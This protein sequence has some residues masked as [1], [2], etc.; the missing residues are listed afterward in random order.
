M[1]CPAD[2][3]HT[4]SWAPKHSGRHHSARR[5]GALFTFL[6]VT[7]TV[8]LLT[9]CGGGGSSGGSGR[10]AP[11]YTISGTVAGLDAGYVVLS[12]GLDQQQLVVNPNGSAY[13]ATFTFDTS[14]PAGA[15]YDI[16]I[17]ND[18]LG[19]FGLQCNVINGAGIMST[20]P[21]S[22]IKVIC[23]RTKSLH[24]LAGKLALSDAVDGTLA[25]ATFNWPNTVAVNAAGYTFIADQTVVR[26]IS[27]AGV[28]TTLAGSYLTTGTID[29]VGASASFSC[30]KDITTD[31]SGNVYVSE[32]TNVIRRITSA[33]VVTTLAGSADQPPGSADGNG[34][35]ARFHWPAGLA[36][37]G[38]GNILV[39][40][41]YNH[42]IRRVTP[43]GVV[44]T[45]AGSAGQP[46]SIDGTISVSRFNFPEGIAVDAAGNILVADSANCTIRIITLSGVVT[47]VA[48]IAG[49][50]GSADGT[51][52]AATF[53]FPT[54]IA[55][56][57]TGNILVADSGNNTIRH[58]AP[59]GIVTTLAGSA[60]QS[61]SVDGTGSAARFGYVE[62]LTVDSTGNILVVDLY[63]HMIRHITPSGIVTTFAGNNGQSK[64]IDGN[65]SAASFIS[66]QG[67]VMGAAGTMLV[68][69][70][71][72][73]TIRQVTPAGVVTTIAGSAGQSG[74]DDG[75]SSAARFNVPTGLAVDSIGNI[76]VADTFN[77]AIR[78]ITP[79]GLVTTMAGSAG[80]SGSTDGTGSDA[81]FNYPKGLAIDAA[82]NV[83]VAD[84]GNHTIRRI[85]PSGV[86]TTLAGSAGQAGSANG[87]GSTARFKGPTGLA[88]DA[89][90]NILVADTGN[91]RIRSITPSGVVVPWA[92]SGQ[93][94][95]TDGTGTTAEFN[96]PQWLTVD[97]GGNIL[98]A[99]HG[100]S[101]N[102]TIRRI[103]PSRVVTARV[104]TTIA[105]GRG[106]EPG[107]LAVDAAGNIL[108]ADPDG[109]IWRLVPSGVSTTLTLKTSL[110]A[111]ADGVGSAAYFSQ[112]RNLE[113]DA[114]GNVFVADKGNST[115]RR[116]AP[117]GT[118]STLA[119]SQGQNGSADGVGSAARF[120]APV[121]LALDASTGDL[122][123]ADQ[124]NHNIRRV[125]MAGVVTT[126][127]GQAGKPGSADG[128]GTAAQF[129]GP[130]GIDIDAQGHIWVADTWNNTVRKITPAGDVSTVAGTAGQWGTDDGI[131]VAARF[132]SPQGIVVDTQGNILVADT[133]NLTLRKIAADGTVTTIVGQAGVSGDLD[134]T[135]NAAQFIRPTFLGRD[136]VGHVYVVDG[137]MIRNLSFDGT[138]YSVN[139]IAGYTKLS[140][141]ID[142]SPA[143]PGTLPR[144]VGKP[145]GLAISTKYIYFT[146]GD[147]V[148]YMD[149]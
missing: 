35:A 100:D 10:N 113:V 110:S 148:F 63:N 131:G 15:G 129:S 1:S 141:V 87:K 108:V 44:T 74:S 56:D 91:H 22:N 77:H 59:F 38:A 28:V 75:M 101:V 143:S 84:T 119:G 97:A 43:S 21:V 19:Q 6:L 3:P 26:R 64:Y 103:T 76:L 136:T 89:A 80:Q 121:G 94:G 73:N 114:E 138:N 55:V 146:S 135:G 42:T 9:S 115:I 36:V 7:V 53:D 67:L 17:V 124:G 134:G 96:S 57:A 98:V 23:T 95:S 24:L 112:P 12:N 61:G 125:T 139:T 86:V 106:Q 2:A 32:C 51:G 68:A 107:A 11:T 130:Q 65:G 149:R 27:P 78:C 29:G 90:G 132:T 41:N 92:G 145:S 122:L 13:D 31:L 123:V 40:D 66:P 14:L 133:A 137:S 81:R 142:P 120:S 62:G 109:S 104:V 99:D 37:D 70:S 46:G 4:R 117:D 52:S 69:D 39:A 144:P 147:A 111:V 128:P 5:C 82:G 47:T 118:V 25:N 30:I 116:I 102:W 88:V 126:V 48:G 79:S 60:G 34:P 105:Y 83:L 71:G 50:S 127:A 93:Q 8:L 85:N 140:T 54:G 33:G 72:N 16:R 18:P 49:Q 20:I 58:I 45:L